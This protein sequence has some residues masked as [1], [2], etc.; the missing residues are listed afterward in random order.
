MRFFNNPLTCSRPPGSREWREMDS[1]GERKEERKESGERRELPLSPTPRC[2]FLFSV[3]YTVPIIW[4]PPKFS[5][6]GVV[7]RML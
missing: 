6:Q 3:L 5:Y 4:M 7:M 2:V 1:G